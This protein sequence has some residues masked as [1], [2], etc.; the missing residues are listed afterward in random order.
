[1]RELKTLEGCLPFEKH[2]S[3]A[4]EAILLIHGYTGT[5]KDLRYLADRLHGAGYAVSVPRLP[6]AGTDIS[7]LSETGRRDWKRR[8]YDS[9]L[10]L[11]ARYGRVF[12]V[13]YSMGAVLALDLASKVHP[14]RLALLAPAIRTTHSSLALTPFLAPFARLLPEVKTGWKPGED[15]DEETLELGRRY[16]SRRDLRSAAQFY[17]LCRETRRRLRKIEAPVMCVVSTAD[18]SV[19][20]EV[21]RLLDRRL[22]RG[23]RRTLVVGNC[24]HDVPQG[25]DR[26]EVAGAVMDW[27][28]E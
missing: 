19:P 27:L 12:L 21:L 24:R 5:P 10:D 8:V 17:R 9:W 4:E 13:G 18:P 16:W 28:A 11:K 26:D 14:K 25:A 1:M 3:G 22:P 20:V 7:D 23:L 6:G 15:D 2:P